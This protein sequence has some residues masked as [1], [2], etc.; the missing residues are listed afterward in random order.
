[1]SDHDTEKVELT[2]RE[3]VRLAA[4]SG[5]L[6][7]QLLWYGRKG[8]A[9]P[10]AVIGIRNILPPGYGARNVLQFE[11]RAW[12]CEQKLGWSHEGWTHLTEEEA[13]AKCDSY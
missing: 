9:V 12:D 4:V 3:Q 5:L 6:H 7:S 11:L 8:N 1:M 2:R 13:L 10:V